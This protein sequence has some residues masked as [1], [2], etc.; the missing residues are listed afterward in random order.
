MQLKKGLP[1]LCYNVMFFIY[2]IGNNNN[3]MRTEMDLSLYQKFASIMNIIC[4][5]FQ[6]RFLFGNVGIV[7][8]IGIQAVRNTNSLNKIIYTN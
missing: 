8:G 3:K 5:R 7:L 4:I 1:T 6:L 2:K